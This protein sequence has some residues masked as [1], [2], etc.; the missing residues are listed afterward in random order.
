VLGGGGKWGAVEVGMLDAL[1]AHGIAPDVIVGCSIGAVNGAAFAAQPDNGGVERLRRFWLDAGNAGMLD[2]AI[3]DRIRAVFGRRSHLFDTEQFGSAIAALIEVDAFAD[4]RVPFQCVAASI[5]YAAEHWFDSGPL[6]SALLASCAIPVLFPAVAV[7]GE[8]FYDGGLVNSIPIDRA[9]QLG[10]TTV[11]V[12]Q[13]GRIEAPLQPPR[14]L[15][16]AGLVAFELARRHRFETFRRGLPEHLELHLLPS[17]NRLA[18]DDRRQLQWRK[19]D[20]T[21][22]L[23]ERARSATHDYL[24]ALES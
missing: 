2:T 7:G 15:H 11:Y 5:E 3:S 22:M 1:V 12:L 24:Q 20:E 19:L 14:R 8:H 4:L 9:V 23:I 10:A 21:E 6:L 17:G 16:Q 18:M 13:V